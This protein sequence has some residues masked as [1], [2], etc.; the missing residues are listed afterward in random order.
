MTMHQTVEQKNTRE[1]HRSC[2]IILLWPLPTA[3]Q[4]HGTVRNDAQYPHEALRSEP[5]REMNGERTEGTV[6]TGGSCGGYV[7]SKRE[8]G[9]DLNSCAIERLVFRLCQET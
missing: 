6:S 1:N 2:K 9:Y 4:I 8:R 3:T 5:I 7:A